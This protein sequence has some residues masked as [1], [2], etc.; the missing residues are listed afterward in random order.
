MAEHNMWF[1]ERYQEDIHKLG[2]NLDKKEVQEKLN[3]KLEMIA[4]SISFEMGLLYL[5]LDQYKLA[6]RMLLNH[7]L[8][9]PNYREKGFVY[10][11]LI[12]SL[13]RI[14]LVY[15]YRKIRDLIKKWM[16]KEKITMLR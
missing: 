14:D 7:L 6:R 4:R 8:N 16:P 9:K 1:L 2:L 12:S 13:I 3:A 10:L 15:Q 11:G 5:S